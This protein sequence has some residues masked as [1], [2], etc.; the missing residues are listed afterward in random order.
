MP[1]KLAPPPPV[2]P[3]TWRPLLA[4]TAEFAAL[5][6][7]EFAHDSDPVGL[8]DPFTGDQRIGHVLGNAGEVF[9]AVFY[10]RAGLRW[11][12]AMLGDAPDPEDLNTADGMDCLKVEFVPKRELWKEDLAVL[13]VAGFK[14]AGKGLVWPQF[15]SS[16]PGWHPWH[17]NQTEADQLLAD[18]PRFTAFYRMFEQH[19]GLYE[20]RDATEI[21]FLP[22]ALPARLLT[23]AD[24]DWRPLLLPPLSGF[25]PSEVTG[26]DLE[27][28]RALKHEPG[29]ECEFD[30]TMMPGGSFYENGR[31]C[32]GRFALLVEKQRGLVIGMDV[33]SGALTPGEAAGR[34]LVKALRMGKVLPGKLHIGGSRLQ[35]VL[36]PLCDELGIGLWPASSLPALEEAVESL[37]Q[38]MLGRG[39]L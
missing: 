10:R 21:P 29:L 27:K 25:E 12:L 11:I 5:Q 32:F 15:R 6:P 33:A 26:A 23:P 34:T 1:A 3:E 36:Q 35:P 24:L 16:E 14:P 17:I 37:S 7:W 13:K 9:A 20:N 4:A 8:I 22:A 18:L 2:A 38:Q 19:P 28:L 30:C 31:P 39:L